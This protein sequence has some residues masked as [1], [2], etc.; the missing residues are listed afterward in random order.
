VTRVEAGLAALVSAQPDLVLLDV[1][2]PAGRAF[3][4]L[5]ALSDVPVLVLAAEAASS[6]RSAP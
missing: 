1:S 6:R 4:P 2:P 5:R 3:D